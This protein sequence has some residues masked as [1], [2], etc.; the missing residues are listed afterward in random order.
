MRI[1]SLRRTYPHNPRG[2]ER[3]SWGYRCLQIRHAL[4]WTQQKFS[5][6]SSINKKLVVSLECGVRERPALS[7]IRKIKAM[8]SAY[9]DIIKEY[10]KAPVRMDRLIPPPRGGNAVR[11]LP[12]QIRRPDDIDSMEEV[13]ANSEPIFFG[14]KTRQRMQQTGMSVRRKALLRK[15]GKAIALSLS[16]KYAEGW[17]PK[18]GPYKA[19]P[20]QSDDTGNGQDGL[21]K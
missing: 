9:A 4:G 6:V 13:G 18:R 17:N 20:R 1:G 14:R 10:K 11:L 5:K 15:R 19:Q 21:G 12:I 16:K 2:L 8:E 3:N 7:T